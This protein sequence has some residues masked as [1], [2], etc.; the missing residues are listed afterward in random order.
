MRFGKTFFVGLVLALVAALSILAATP[1]GKTAAAYVAGWFKNLLGIGAWE[2][3]IG[4]RMVKIPAGSFMMGSPPSEPGRGG[5]ETQHRV[6]ISRLFL[7]GTTEV[8]QGQWQTVMGSNPSNF[9]SC[10]DDCPVEWVS[11]LDVVDFCNRLSDR[12]GLT[13]CYSGN[14]DSISWNRSCTGYRLPTEAEWEYAAR[15]GTAGPFHTGNCLSTDDANYDG[16]DPLEGCPKGEH[17]QTPIPVGALASN[18]W[19]LYDVHGNV[20]EW[21]WDFKGD[22][23]SGPVTDPTGPSGGTPHVDRG[24]SRGRGA[25]D[26]RS[27]NRYGRD[28][29]YRGQSLGFRLARSLR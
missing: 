27:A 5:D 11:W 9:K 17:R 3:S 24:G 4:C 29:D 14:A 25:A 12:E 13:R 18:A 1:P 19:G 2:S 20:W 10:G 23:P 8:T 16:D 7:M 21:V 15:A 22:Y 6:T 26:C 28:P